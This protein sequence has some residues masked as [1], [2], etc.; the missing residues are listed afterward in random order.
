MK[1]LKTLLIATLAA[2]NIYTLINSDKQQEQPTNEKPLLSIEHFE[3]DYYQSYLHGSV[4]VDH[5]TFIAIKV[6]YTITEDES[7]IYL[8]D[9]LN[10]QEYAIT[11]MIID[12]NNGQWKKLKKYKKSIDTSWSGDIIKV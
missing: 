11:K 10:N 7:Y 8:L 5:D 6:A 12:I 9:S 4:P 3:C 2:A 1:K